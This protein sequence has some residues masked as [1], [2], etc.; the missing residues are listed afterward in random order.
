MRMRMMR[1][2]NS[3]KM[4]CEAVRRE[5]EDDYEEDLNMRI[6]N[7]WEIYWETVQEAV[8]EAARLPWAETYSC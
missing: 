7:P 6:L 5:D 8:R 2:L 4:F 3:W 1:I